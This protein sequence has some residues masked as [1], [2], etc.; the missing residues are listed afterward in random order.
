MNRTSETNKADH[1]VTGPGRREVG[2]RILA[3]RSMKDEGVGA[4]STRHGVAGS[5]DQDIRL[6]ASYQRVA[7][8]PAIQHIFP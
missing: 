1:I 3:E 2:D 4:S 8:R 6:G 5:A 7:T